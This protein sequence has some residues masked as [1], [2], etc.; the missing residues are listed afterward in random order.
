MNNGFG[1]PTVSEF[2][3]ISLP[4]NPNSST[5]RWSRTAGGLGQLLPL[6]LAGRDVGGSH[7]SLP[8][9]LPHS[10]LPPLFSIISTFALALACFP[11]VGSSTHYFY[12]CKA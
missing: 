1:F 2:S 12:G 10:S 4:R 11:V 9:S 6:P 7:F 5:S 3:I 8:P